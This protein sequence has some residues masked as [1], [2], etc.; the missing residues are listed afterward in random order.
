V[1]LIAGLLCRRRGCTGIGAVPSRAR[2]NRRSSF[3]VLS[4]P[5]AAGPEIEANDDARRGLA[6]GG[7]AAAVTQAAQGIF[8][9]VSFIPASSSASLQGR[10]E[11]NTV[12]IVSSKSEQC[13]LAADEESIELYDEAAAEQQAATTIQSAVR[14][15]QLRQRVKDGTVWAEWRPHSIAVAVDSRP[16]APCDLWTAFAALLNV[17]IAVVY[18]QKEQY[19]MKSMEPLISCQR[20]QSANAFSSC[21]VAMVAYFLLVVEMCSCPSACYLRN[22]LQDCNAY[23]HVERTRKSEPHIRWHIQCYH[24]ETQSYTEQKTDRNGNTRT[25][26]RTRRVRRNTWAATE[27]YSPYYWEDI[28]C[29]FPDIGTASLTRLTFGKSY[30]FADATSA[31]HFRDRKQAFIRMNRR[32]THYDFSESFDI[33]G[34]GMSFFVILKPE[35]LPRQARDKHAGKVEQ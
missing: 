33:N 31:H 29:P 5:A 2:R 8:T 15:R 32:D 3:Y 11:G 35:Q 17:V 6:N 20:C 4:A 9:G 7:K 1:R 27:I 13:E 28:S 21:T 24:Y 14:G 12:R 19:C 16:A 22:I 18:I 23:Q 34:A 10:A 26:R 30:V 25:V